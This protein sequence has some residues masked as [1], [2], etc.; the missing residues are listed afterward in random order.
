MIFTINKKKFLPAQRL[1]WELKNYYKLLI[2]GYGSGKT[3]IGALRMIRNSYLNRGMPNQYISPTFPMAKKTIIPT[4]EAMLDKAGLRYKHNKTDHEFYIQ[5]WDGIIWVGSGSDPDSLKGANLASAGIDEP[6]IQSEEVFKQMMARVRQPGAKCRE[7]FMTGTPEQLNWGYE[8]ARTKDKDVG[9]AI[10]KTLDNTHLPQ[11]FLDNLVAGYS[12]EERKAYLE[13]QFVNLTSGRVCK[14]FN[15]ADHVVHRSDLDSLY[16]T[17]P[18]GIGIDFNVDYYSALAYFDINGS[19]HYFKEFRKANTDTYEMGRIIRDYFADKTNMQIT[20]YPDATGKARK[21][22]STQ[23]DHQ[24]LKDYGFNVVSHS[25]NPPVR[26]RVNAW[27]K[28]LREKRITIQKGECPNLIMDN[29]VMIWKNGDLDKTTNP[30]LTHA[31]DGASYPVAYKYPVRKREGFT[32][33]W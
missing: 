31:F 9:I 32:V 11:D 17:I 33:Q 10:A 23:S 20:V 14:P 18:I 30:K 19:L 25:S 22:S 21:T 4:L 6:F 7:I 15:E 1:F 26:D 13:G 28:L 27:N 5:N 3:Y 24:I 8:L 29:E 2:G 12:D 16:K